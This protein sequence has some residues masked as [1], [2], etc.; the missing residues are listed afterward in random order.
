MRRVRRDERS[1]LAVIGGGR[2]ARVILS[3]LSRLEL[4]YQIVVVST[5]NA[6]RFM[7]PSFNVELVPGL[8]ELWDQ[9]EVKAAIVVNAAR[10]H[11]ETALQLIEAGASVLVEKPLALRT[12][13]VDRLVQRAKSCEVQMVPSLTFLHCV[14]LHRFSEMIAVRGRVARAVVEWYDPRAE[15]RY[16]EDKLYDPGVSVAQDVMPHVWSILASTLGFPDAPVVL[17]SCTAARGGKRAEFEFVFSKIP[18]HVAIERD[19]PVRRRFL[20]VELLSGLK[21]AIDFTDEPGT[22]TMGLETSSGDPEWERRS[23]PVSRQLQ[24][25]LSLIDQPSGEVSSVRAAFGSVALAEDA[26]TLLK[27][28]QE[29]WLGRRSIADSDND[30]IYAMRELASPR[31]HEAGDIRPGDR[32]ALDRWIEEALHRIRSDRDFDGL[33]CFLTIQSV[34]SSRRKS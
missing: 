10:Q 28:Q 25:F 7:D 21:M 3:V 9:Y 20:A 32:D 24:A 6:K 29:A 31:L 30:T 33:N 11:A 19:A 27:G 12:S 14:Y 22:I 18:C 16:G 1:T 23:R 26:D 4:P 5:A 2:W 17:G 13:D 8:N 15:L 34:L